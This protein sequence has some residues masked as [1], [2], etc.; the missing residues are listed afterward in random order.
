V[1]QLGKL[2]GSWPEIQKDTYAGIYNSKSFNLCSEMPRFG[3][4]GALDEKQIKNLV[5]L[6]L[7]P[8]SPVNK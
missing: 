7:D 4:I 3:H 2:G 1:L 8:E 6:L 5:A